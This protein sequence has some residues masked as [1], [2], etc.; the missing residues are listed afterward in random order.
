MPHG[1]VLGPLLFSIYLNKITCLLNGKEV[2][3]HA[4]DTVVV[5]VDDNWEAV[6]ENTD[7]MMSPV[8]I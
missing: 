5:V 6:D 7:H 8:K 4:D 3:C 1:I 2:Y